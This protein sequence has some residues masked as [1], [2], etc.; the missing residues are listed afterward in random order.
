MGVM[1]IATV[2][3][4]TLPYGWGPDIET[5]CA[6][7][8]VTAPAAAAK[9]DPGLDIAA[10]QL[11]SASAKF[12][13]NWGMHENCTCRAFDVK[14]FA[15]GTVNF[16]TGNARLKPSWDVR[17]EEPALF[18]VG[19][20]GMEHV[21]NLASHGG[22]ATTSAQS[23]QAGSTGGHGGVPAGGSGDHELSLAHDL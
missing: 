7:A 10:P 14:S 15:F 23:A 6:A 9:D 20:D 19:S 22:T 8:S 2:T 5:H 3:T 1:T 11:V 21:R 4:A 16:E 17:S 18:W 12:L 13:C